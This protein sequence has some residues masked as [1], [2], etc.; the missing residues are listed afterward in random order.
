[1]T[2]WAKPNLDEQCA[3]EATVIAIPISLD[4]D[5]ANM[6]REE[7]GNLRRNH[8]Q[9]VGIPVAA[10]EAAMSDRY[11]SSFR[12]YNLKVYRSFE[13]NGRSVL[14]SGSQSGFAIGFLHPML[15]SDWAIDA[16]TDATMLFR[17]L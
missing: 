3:A 15:D 4:A 14:A 7:I 5:Q 17:P 11:V 2:S 10:G 13:N 1:M 8:T 16:G 6:D 9:Y 12:V